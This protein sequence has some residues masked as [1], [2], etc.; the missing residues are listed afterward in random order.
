MKEIIKYYLNKDGQIHN[1]NNPALIINNHIYN[2]DNYSIIAYFRHGKLHRDNG[3]AWI[4]RSNQY[5]TIQLIYYING[6]LISEKYAVPY[7]ICG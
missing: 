5:D 1:D 6:R 2:M 7:Y 4:C 3:P